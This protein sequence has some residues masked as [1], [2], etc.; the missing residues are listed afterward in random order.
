MF[1]AWRNGFQRPTK[2]PVKFVAMSST[3][4]NSRGHFRRF[5]LSSWQK[6]CHKFRRS[7]CKLVFN[8]RVYWMLYFKLKSSL[9]ISRDFICSQM[10]YSI[11]I[12][13]LQLRWQALSSSLFVVKGYFFSFTTSAWLM[14]FLHY[15]RAAPDQ[16]VWVLV[17]TRFFVLCSQERFIFALKMPLRFS[18]A[19]TLG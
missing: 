6:S 11:K 16:K 1:S 2:T 13:L 10:F 9:M 19:N 3:L 8:F 12:F 5:V 7:Q 18:N 4:G 17:L 14:R 15:R